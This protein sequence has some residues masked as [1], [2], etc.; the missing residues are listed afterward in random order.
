MDFKNKWADLDLDDDDDEDD[1]E[2]CDE[3]DEKIKTAAVKVEAL[4]GA[5]ESACQVMDRATQCHSGGSPH[6]Q[7][8]TPQQYD[9]NINNLL[10][11]ETRIEIERMN[12]YVKT[13]YNN[14]LKQYILVEKKSKKAPLT[15]EQIAAC[16][17]RFDSIIETNLQEA[18]R[19]ELERNDRTKFTFGKYKGRSM[20]AI[21]QFDTAYIAWLKKQKWIRAYPDVVAFLGTV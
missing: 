13:I 19:A 7:T 20:K 9:E 6:A 12:E 5:I 8:L 2:D 3:E 16:K 1:D 17:V 21:A 4:C 18:K 14:K 10:D 11:Q 15:L